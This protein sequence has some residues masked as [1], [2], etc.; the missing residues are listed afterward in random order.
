MKKGLIVGCLAVL[1][2]GMISLS[3][4]FA[5]QEVNVEV[6]NG[7]AGAVRPDLDKATVE[8]SIPAIRDG[9]AHIRLRSPEK[10]FVSTDFPWVEGTE[11]IDSTVAIR[12]GKASFQYMFP[13]RGE[14][15]LSVEW[16]D[17]NGHPEGSRQFAVTIEE[18]PKEVQNAL[19]FMAM[20][21]FFGLLAG[22]GLSRRR[23][24]IHAA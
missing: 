15:P 16:F 6:K 17:E 22:F 2:V 10:K 18:N 21:A 9:S 13:I 19:I 23:R 11:L 7:P 5:E 24:G 12:D 14:Y 3:S 1:A 4:A 8:L 20:L